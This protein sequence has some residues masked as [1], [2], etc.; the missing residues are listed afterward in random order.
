MTINEPLGLPQ[1]SVRALLTFTF[2]FAAIGMRFFGHQDDFIDATAVAAMSFYLG[3]RSSETNEYPRT[4]TAALPVGNTPEV[5]PSV[6]QG[7]DPL[8]P[9]TPGAK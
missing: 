3:T 1:G 7:D 5:V 8:G 6:S 4:T 2:V 9:I